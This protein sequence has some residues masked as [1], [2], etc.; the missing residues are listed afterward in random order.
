MSLKSAVIHN[1]E[2]E[3]AE[4]IA[5][6]PDVPPLVITKIDVQRRGVHYTDRAVNAMDPAKHQQRSAAL[7]GSRDASLTPLP[8]SLLFRDG[9]TVLTDPTPVGENPYHVDFVDGILVITDQGRVVEEVEYW[10]VPDFFGKLTSSGTPMKFVV[11]ARPQRINVMP[12]SYCH[13]WTNDKGCKYCDIVN[14]LK[15][16]KSELGV[17][18][19]LSLAD[20][21]ETVGEALKQPGRFS[22]ICLTAGSDTRG[23]DPFD[24]EVDYY[25]KLL[26]AIGEHFSTPKFPSQLIGTAFTEKQL[27]RLYTETGLMSYTADIEVLNEKL[28]NW[29]CPGKAEW[30]G[31]KEWKQRLIR[32]VDIFGPGNVNTGI[33]GGVELARP[34]GFTSEDDALKHTL[35]EAEYLAS[36]GVSTVSMVWVVRPKS[37]FSDQKNASLDYYV[38]LARGLQALRLKYNLSLDFD[39]YRRCGNHP[40]SDLMRLV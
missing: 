12:S 6:Y 36:R 28:F 2:P 17:P 31:Y 10:P 22:T 37:Y 25:I 13:F 23:A 38:R 33:V 7:F 16:E 39:D 32:A 8:E 19:K 18:G 26:K 21:K 3:L 34:H 30:I 20:V 40:D 15:H 11:T 29:I 1:R 24:E 5:R 14:Y 4:I 27:V 35:E 9:T